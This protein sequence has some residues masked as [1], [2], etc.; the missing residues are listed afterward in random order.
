MGPLCRPP[1]NP[2][3]GCGS[4][5]AVLAGSGEHPRNRPRACQIW[6][7]LQK[8]GAR[9]AA[10]RAG[11]GRRANRTSGFTRVILLHPW[12]GSSLAFWEQAASTQAGSET[13]GRGPAI[14]VLRAFRG[15][16]GF[17]RSSSLRALVGG[18]QPAHSRQTVRASRRNTGSGLSGPAWALTLCKPIE[19][20]GDA[21][22][23]NPGHTTR[24]KP[25][26][27]SF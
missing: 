12:T 15:I 24:S 14:R 10:V 8:P 4:S 11:W 17:R 5:P 2:K 6:E 19:L 18:A 25:L 20:P 23:L 16:P 3:R 22:L 1:P 9:G 27:Q 26:G 7:V 21:R 13:L